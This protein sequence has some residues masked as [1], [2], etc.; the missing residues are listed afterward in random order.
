MRT[1]VQDL[2][3]ALRQ[4]KKNPSFTAIAVLT[5]ALGIAVN[6]TMFSLVSAFLLRP[7]SGHEPERVAVITSVNP[8]SGFMS[9]ASTV[10]APNYL[11]WRN[12]NTAFNDVAAADVYRTI[13]LTYEKQTEVLTE[14]AVSANFF[15]VLGANP[16]LGR[17]FAAGEDHAGQDHVVLLS[18]GL[19]ERRFNSD[20][21]IVGKSI[22]LNRE[23]FTVIGV[24]PASFQLLGFTSQLWTPLTLSEADQSES[25]RKARNLYVFGR[26][27]PGVSLEQARA[28]MVT[29]GQRAAASF[30]ETEKGWGVAVRTLPDFLV[31][32]FS[33]RSALAVLM[34]TVAFVLLIA[35]ANVAGLLLARASGRKKELAIRRAL[36]AG[37]LRIVRQMLTEGLMIALLGGGTGLL[38]AKWGIDVLRANTTFNEAMAAVP[39]TLDWNVV[40][41]TAAISIACALLCGIAPALSASRTDINSNLKDESRSTSQG[42]SRSRLRKIMVTSEIA[43]ALFL[44]IG[45][46]LLLHGMY[47]VEHQNLGFR[48]DHLMTASVNLDQASYKDEQARSTFVR[49]VNARLRTLPGV[50]AV[51]ASSELPATGAGSV[52]FHIKDQPNATASESL[53]ALDLIVTEDYLRTV[54]VSLRNG[55]AFT[56]KDDAQSPRVVLV[57]DAFVQ[58][59]FNGKDA[60]GKQVKL[61]THG[62]SGAWSEIV[63]IVANVK[64]YSEA[65]RED[66]EVYEAYAQRP[67]ES[68]SFVARTSS[69]PDGMASALR[70][71]IGQVDAELPLQRVMSMPGVIAQQRQGNPLFVHMLEMF[72]VMALILSAIGIYGLIAYSVGERTH[73]IGIRMAMGARTYDMLRMV[74]WEGLKMAVIGGVIGTVMALP[75]PKLFESIFYE[76]HVGE[77]RL[78][79]IVPAVVLMVAM[80]A[81]YFPARRASRIDPMS[82]LRQD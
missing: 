47:M 30:P 72:A 28:E 79:V 13:G 7:P 63:G 6:A 68:F 38:L 34:T 10:S 60:L 48:A 8:A 59:Y 45:T 11:A 2:R 1:M 33:I 25:A 27:K 43:L 29:A 14:A 69:D 81:A 39:L 12:G 9:D 58:K 67:V 74:G 18:H 32:L 22:R 66:P 64:T 54:G 65:T 80:L 71:T 61:D 24:M 42:R 31:H 16:Q 37:R 36:G 56:E 5:L 46:G 75:L 49:E 21:S 70:T 50:E 26:L 19:W 3:Y 73:E 17:T 40:I 57:N 20:A 23:P 41:F 4:L 52:T 15:G 35:C 82:A 77:P 62:D 44:L 51:A 55:R 53:T 78:Y 76:L